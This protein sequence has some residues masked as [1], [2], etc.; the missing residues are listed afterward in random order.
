MYA[1]LEFPITINLVND[2]VRP[3]RSQELMDL[4]LADPL[5]RRAT[6]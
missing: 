3:L 5:A 2:V 4:G 1:A 6:K